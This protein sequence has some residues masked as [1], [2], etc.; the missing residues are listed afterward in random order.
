MTSRLLLQLALGGGLA[1]VGAGEAALLGGLRQVLREDLHAGLGVLDALRVAGLELVDERDVHAADEADRVGLGGLGGR[2]TGEVRGLL[3]G[4]DERRDVVALDHGVDDA[5]GGLRVLLGGGLQRGAVGEA[6]ADDRVVALLGQRDQALLLV[7][8]RLTVGGLDVGGLV[9]ELLL[10][11]LQ[12]GERGVVEGLVALAADVV[13][14]G[15]ALAALALAAVAAAAVAAGAATG[16]RREC[17]RRDP[18]RDAGQA[19]YPTHLKFPILQAPQWVLSSAHINARRPLRE[20]DSAWP[21]SIRA[22]GRL[23][24]CEPR[25]RKVHMGMQH[26]PRQS[27]SATGTVESA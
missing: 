8:V 22:D 2:D 20:R 18:H 16:G 11:L 4:E 3:L 1:L 21:L 26:P 27:R 14:D 7:G 5:E 15:K 12:T 6:D 13:R 17:Q 19:G 25:D 9:A 10:R 23:R 24:P